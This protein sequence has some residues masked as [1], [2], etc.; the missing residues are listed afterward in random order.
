MIID[1]SVVLNWLIRGGEF[2]KECLKLREAFERGSISIKVPETVVYDVCSRI[3]ESDLP[4]DVASKLAHLTYEYLRF[5]SIE[6]DG[7]M[8]PEI[9]RLCRSLNLDL[10]VASCVV[11][12]N[13]LGEIYVTA[14]KELQKLLSDSGFKVSHVSDIF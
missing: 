10:A 7:S 14:D 11:L 8:L 12:S 2:E 5:V 9:V 6:L 4:V 13:R 3:V 1:S